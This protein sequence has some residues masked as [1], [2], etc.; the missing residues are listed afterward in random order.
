MAYFR[1]EAHAVQGEGVTPEDEVAG[2]EGAGVTGRPNLVATFPPHI[3][4]RVDQEIPIAVD[5]AGLHFFD[6][7]TG[8]PLR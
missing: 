2:T 1:I 4:L 6:P 8:A 5:V 7:E 3:R